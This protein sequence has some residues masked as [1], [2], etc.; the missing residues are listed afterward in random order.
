MVILIL[1]GMAVLI[2][3][4]ILLNLVSSYMQSKKT[5]LTIMR[6]NGF[7]T[8]ET[9][10]YASMESYL[11]T[12]CGIVLGLIIGHLLGTYASRVMEQTTIQYVGEPYW[13]SF[14]FSALIT[15]VIS[16]VIHGHTFRQIRNLK[17][18]DLKE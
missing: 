12:L 15:G 16:W 3:W 2:A 5:K 13:A 1:G 8:R 17:L 18:S 7:T 10:R 4:F 6:I 11:T 14:V 9:I